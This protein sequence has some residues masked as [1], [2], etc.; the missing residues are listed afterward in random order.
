[1]D[2]LW[3][4]PA[5]VSW[6]TARSGLPACISG[7]E[8]PRA[9]SLRET[10]HDKDPSSTPQKAA[11]KDLLTDS[12]PLNLSH[13]GLGTYCIYKKNLTI[14]YCSH[15]KINA[16]IINFHPVPMLHIYSGISVLFSVWGHMQQCSR[17]T[18]DLSQK[19]S[20]DHAFNLLK[21]LSYSIQELQD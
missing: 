13:F 21:H 6:G 5:G 18:Q 16:M 10:T 7:K 11:H 9:S 8:T 19:C 14:R 17:V 4:G 1:M 2:Y 20:G 3:S 12:L 15:T